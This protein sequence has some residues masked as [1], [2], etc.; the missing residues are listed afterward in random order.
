M[1]CGGWRTGTLDS[2]AA[3]LRRPQV[4]SSLG[5]TVA[6]AQVYEYLREFDS[7][8]DGKISFP[9]FLAMMWRL[10]SGP[11]EKEIVSEMF[12]ARVCA[13]TRGGVPRASSGA[14]ALQSPPLLRLRARGGAC[15]RS[16]LPLP[17]G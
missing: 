3:P 14:V 1:C 9:E 6:D 4:L 7:N 10:Q 11:S 16:R 15:A 8:G 12:Q 2:L 5:Q 17:A 13:Q